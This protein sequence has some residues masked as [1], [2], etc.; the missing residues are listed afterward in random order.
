MDR[1]ISK[2]I[3]IKRRLKAGMIV[4]L[5]VLI[6]VGMIWIIGAV[7]TRSVDWSRIRYS[8]ARIGTVE[9]TLNASGTIVP[10]VEQ[11]VSAPAS[12]IIRK[13][14]IRSGDKVK[15]GQSILELEKDQL[16]VEYNKAD[17]ELDLLRFKKTKLESDLERKKKELQASREVKE[18]QAQFA[19][20]QYDRAKRLNEIGAYSEEDVQRAALSAEIAKRELSVLILQIDN[21]CASMEMELQNLSTEINLQ[22]NSL[23]EI[24]HR[25]TLSDAPSPL[26]GI[27]TWV[28]DSIGFPV[29]EGDVVARVADLSRY[30]LQGE[31]SSVNSG[32]LKVGQAVR[33]RI[34]EKIVNGNITSISPLVRNGVSYFYAKLIEAGDEALQPNMRVDVYVVTSVAHDVLCVANGPFYRGLHDQTVFVIK[35]NSAEAHKAD[36][37]ASSFDFVELR[38]DIS[39]GDSVII[40]DMEKYAEAK[41]IN[42]KN[43]DK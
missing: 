4:S 9:K 16:Q 41:T 36:I 32:A 7:G 38:G 14:I 39:P 35:G 1:E 31:I 3:K 28:N 5:I 10:E 42:I 29:R 11:A 6:F 25:L 8:V 43:R 13:A 15:I 21:Q 34:G 27:V 22:M 26:D 37:G 24:N 40:S 23:D 12:S 19:G 2:E 18:L 17:E 30:R 20:K 33:I